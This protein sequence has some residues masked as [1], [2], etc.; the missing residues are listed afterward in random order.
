MSISL[1]INIVLSKRIPILHNP[2]NP[3]CKYVKNNVRKEGEGDKRKF[4][5]NKSVASAA[6]LDIDLLAGGFL[7]ID[8]VCAISATVTKYFM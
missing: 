5:C 4:N 3:V 7:G 6:S 8:R 1:H 2:S